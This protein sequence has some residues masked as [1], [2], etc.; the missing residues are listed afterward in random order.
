MIDLESKLRD[1]LLY[2][3]PRTRR[4]WKKIMIVVEGIYRL[5]EA[6]FCSP[7]MV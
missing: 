6:E 5:A 3:Q 1:A 2:G 7:E 4:P